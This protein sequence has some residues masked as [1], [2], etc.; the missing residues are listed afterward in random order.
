MSNW[1]QAQENQRNYNHSE[2]SDEDEEYSDDEYAP[3]E[4][5][6]WGNQ[7]ITP[8]G[9]TNVE[10]SLSG[11]QS[12]VDPNIKVKAGGVGSG[13]LHRRGGNFIPV[14]EQSI[15]D[16][17]L[18]KPV[19]KAPGS[20]KKR[21]G[22]PK[23]RG[24]IR[25]PPTRRPIPSSMVPPSSSHYR[26]REVIATGPWASSELSSQPFWEQP[27]SASSGTNASKWASSAPAAAAPPPRRPAYAAPPAPAPAPPTKATL[28]PP[29]Q[30]RTTTF[31]PTASGSAASKWATPSTVAAPP[32]TYHQP[33]PP[34]QHQPPIIYHRLDTPCLNFNIELTP[35][36]NATL[37]VYENDN[38][39]EVVDQFEKKHHLTMSE[40]AKEKFAQRV[41]MLLSQYKSS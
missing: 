13:Q 7:T 31:T 16:R 12:L 14:D 39:I 15:I 32:Q 29:V 34:Q 21:G 33:A 27:A 1:N 41:A 2:Y 25:P 20:K 3:I 6:S 19:P 38:P 11:W 18:G 36:V 35:G 30:A 8:E 5:S 10:V 23:S 4:A 24:A 40:S 37:S 28:P 9:T 17:R 26:G 22:K